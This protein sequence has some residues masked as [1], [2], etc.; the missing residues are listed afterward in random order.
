MKTHHPIPLVR[1]FGSLL[2]VFLTA[3]SNAQAEEKPDSDAGLAG[4]DSRPNVL[5]IA[6]DDLNDWVGCLG[7]HPQTITP[8]VDR[9]ASQ[10]VIFTN[11][12][13][14]APIC[15]P[16]R[17]AIMTGLSPSTTGIY[18]QINDKNIKK[19]N[20]AAA[21]AIF[22]PDWFEQNGYTTIG[23]GKIYHNGDQANTFDEFFGGVDFGPRPKERVA[24]DPAKRGLP[25]GTST[26]WAAFPE[27]DEEMPDYRTADY[28]IS[29]LQEK[30]DKPFFMAC[31]FVR[32][33][34]PWYCPQ[35]WFDMH[36]LDKIQTPPYLPEDMA[37]VPEMGRRVAE[38]P[39]MPTTEWAI[40]SG[41]WPKM[42]QA[43]LAC[44]TFVDA[45]IGK[46]LDALDQSPYRDHTIVVLWSDHGYHL[47]EKNRFAKQ[48]IWE[49]DT[50]TVFIWRIPGM[51]PGRSCSA[52]TQLLDI[53]PTLLDLCGLPANPRNEGH[54]LVPL[55]SNT[56]ADWPHAAIS[57]YGVGNISIRDRTHRYIVYEDGSEELYDMV[58][59]PNEWHNQAK[60]EEFAEIK[61]ALREKRPMHQAPLSPVSQ[62]NVNQYWRDK[63][64]ANNP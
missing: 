63:I 15:G 55:L 56:N 62:Y 1:I 41:E 25:S 53:Y 31:G 52:P 14:Q 49:R 38:M 28:I 51:E 60:N 4:P 6:V 27:K 2:V 21:E 3:C 8:N 35:K 7:G 54:S 37:D 16:S 30:H 12:H 26:D 9:L 57:V 50:R 45:Q 18:L 61:A 34:V 44:V 59:D 36:P 5:F 19:A 24:W 10:G 48:A 40:E 17:A 43:Y 39:M 33:H 42:V 13:C 23:A 29:R 22:L 32:P 64:R 20:L 47:G 46:V 58:S 11:A